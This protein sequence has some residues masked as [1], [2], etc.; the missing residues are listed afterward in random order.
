MIKA[1]ADKI[2]PFPQSY[3]QILG[4]RIL[5]LGKA[6]NGKAWRYFWRKLGDRLINVSG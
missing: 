4:I 2:T 3:P 5:R 6:N 1:W